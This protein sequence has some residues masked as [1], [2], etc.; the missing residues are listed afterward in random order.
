M[1]VFFKFEKFKLS[2]CS[3]KLRK[4]SPQNSARD[5]FKVQ[6]LREV[7]RRG[8]LGS[9]LLIKIPWCIHSRIEGCLQRF[10]KSLKSLFANR[11]N[12][13]RLQKKRLNFSYF[14]GNCIFQT[15]LFLVYTSNTMLSVLPKFH[16]VL[17]D[18]KKLCDNLLCFTC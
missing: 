11:P 16:F 7:L 10:G 9:C 17:Y 4:K 2:M 6:L 3:L 12:E 13:T 1:H 15:S 5:H 14:R 8:L 18:Q